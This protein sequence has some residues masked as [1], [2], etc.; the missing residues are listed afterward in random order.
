M[1]VDYLPQ[2][3]RVRVEWSALEEGNCGSIT[4]GA[5]DVD[6]MAGDPAEIGRAKEDVVALVVEDVFESGCGV[7]HVSARR[8]DHSLGF[9]GRA[10]GCCCR[11][12]YG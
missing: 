9:S 11:R 5:I 3:A 6:R 4:K 1:P 8:V 7:N 2:A 12:R 10:T